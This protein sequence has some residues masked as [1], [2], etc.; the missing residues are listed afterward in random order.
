MKHLSSEIWLQVFNEPCLSDKDLASAQR[1]CQRFNTLI[2][3]YIYPKRTFTLTIDSP[4]Y[5][6]WKL[7][8]T[9]LKRPAL[10]EQFRHI[11]LEFR[12]RDVHYKDTWFKAWKWQR[13]DRQHL[14]ATYRLWATVL[15]YPWRQVVNAGLNSEALLPLILCFTPNLK[16]LDLRNVE[17]LVV[18]PWD[19]SEPEDDEDDYRSPPDP[20]LAAR[21]IGVPKL[22]R[23]LFSR[24]A[25]SSREPLDFSTSPDLNQ[26]NDQDRLWFWTALDR[27]KGFGRWL[28]GFASLEDLAVLGK[29]TLLNCHQALYLPQI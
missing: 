18:R 8:R 22:S 7:A 25:F 1:T 17:S 14:E 24:R 19:Q 27:A 5:S 20:E 16:F 13:S 28:P 10:G 3:R 26:A 21:A 23:E 29:W 2:Q 4:K 6:C 9:L 15:P 11:R 12:R